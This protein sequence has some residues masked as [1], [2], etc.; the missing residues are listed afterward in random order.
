MK[1]KNTLNQNFALAFNWFLCFCHIIAA[2]GVVLAIGAGE[3]YAALSVIGYIFV[4]GLLHIL[5]AILEA[6]I[7][8]KL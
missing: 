8:R 1:M 4:A 3:Y 5:L 6:V 7:S 2:L